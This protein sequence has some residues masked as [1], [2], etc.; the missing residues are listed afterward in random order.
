[1]P[2]FSLELRLPGLFFNRGKTFGWR[3]VVDF[4]SHCRFGQWQAQDDCCECLAS[5]WPAKLRLVQLPAASRVTSQRLAL[6][7]CEG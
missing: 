5:A 2:R 7:I 6:I 3:Q 4:M 1:M